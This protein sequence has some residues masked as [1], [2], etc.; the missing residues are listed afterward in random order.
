MKKEIKS[1]LTYF[2]IE[3]P[4][5]CIRVSRLVATETAESLVYRLGHKSLSALEIRPG[6]MEES[7]APIMADFANEFI[8]G[9]VFTGGNVQEETLFILRPE[10]SV[11][12]LLCAKMEGGFLALT[13]ILILILIYILILIP[14][15]PNL[16]AIISPPSFPLP[17]YSH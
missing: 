2:I 8:G 14:S 4:R 11:A 6:F 9:G 16:L 1:I 5:G 3:E 13:L 7:D 17:F 10:L 15:R 12:M